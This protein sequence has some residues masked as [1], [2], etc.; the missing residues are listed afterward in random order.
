MNIFSQDKSNP[1][2]FLVN[3]Y[4]KYDLPSLVSLAGMGLTSPE[5]PRSLFIM[6]AIEKLVIL[7]FS[8]LFE[9]WFVWFNFL[10]RAACWSEEVTNE[11]TLEIV[12]SR[13]AVDWLWAEVGLAGGACGC[14]AA[15]ETAAKFVEIIYFFFF[16]TRFSFWK[17]LV[18]VRTST[19]WKISR[20]NA[21]AGCW[22]EC[23][24]RLVSAS[25]PLSILC[26]SASSS[27]WTSVQLKPAALLLSKTRLAATARVSVSCPCAAPTHI[28]PRGTKTLSKYFIFF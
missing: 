17:V 6:A 12:G 13:Q 23:S 3:I 22:A 21:E 15:A 11:A 28:G 26:V 19:G 25:V 2:S 18:D 1:I 8:E 14:T 4:V 16:Y 24:I 9:L 10:T 27:S 7:F 20:E 5:L